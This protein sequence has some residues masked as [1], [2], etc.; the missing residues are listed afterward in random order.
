VRFSFKE[1]HMQFIGCHG[2][3]R[4]IRGS[5][6]EGPAVSPAGIRLSSSSKK[7]I[8]TR[9]VNGGPDFRPMVRPRGKVDPPPIFRESNLNG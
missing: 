5:A 6:V 9:L 3:P 4:E 1:N 7:L 8:W 2:S